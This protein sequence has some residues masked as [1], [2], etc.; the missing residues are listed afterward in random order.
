MRRGAQC[1]RPKQANKTFVAHSG[2]MQDILD[3]LVIGVKKHIM[4]IVCFRYIKIC[5]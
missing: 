1:Q 5:Y 2:A 3:I 4:V